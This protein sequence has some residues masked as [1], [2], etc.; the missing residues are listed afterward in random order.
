MT[1]NHGEKILEAVEAHWG[2]R[3]PDF[4]PE[5]ACCRAWAE[6]D[7]HAAAMQA[8]DA[9]IADLEQMLTECR[10]HAYPY[11]K[12]RGDLAEAALAAMTAERD[13]AKQ[14]AAAR[15]AV[16]NLPISDSTYREKLN[17]LSEAE[18]A[19]AR[20][21]LAKERQQEGWDA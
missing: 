11:Q 2:E 1:T 6:V 19:L 7:A 13:A 5:C 4:D 3:C 9:R 12:A 15:S 8:K 14:W 10:D 18:D 20:A 16:V 21:F 17:A